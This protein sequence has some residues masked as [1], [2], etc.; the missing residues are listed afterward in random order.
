MAKDQAFGALIIVICAILA[1]AFVLG[2]FLYDP[3]LR[4]ILNVGLPE[5][6]RFWIVATPVTVGFVGILGIGAWI[7]FTMATTPPPKPIEELIDES[8]TQEE[9][10]ET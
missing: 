9:T 7:G 10:S 6:V 2:M 8:V 3:Y 5:N 1:V 4:S